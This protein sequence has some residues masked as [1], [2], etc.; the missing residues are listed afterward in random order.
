M[1]RIAINGPLLWVKVNPS[2]VQRGFRLL[3]WKTS[4]V[5]DYMI[6]QDSDVVGVRTKLFGVRLKWSQSYEFCFSSAMAQLP[7]VG[8]A[9]CEFLEYW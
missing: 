9:V 3:R 7:V 5:T 2:S 6:I 8:R 4:C 1:Q